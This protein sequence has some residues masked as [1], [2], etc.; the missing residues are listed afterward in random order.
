MEDTSLLVGQIPAPLSMKA[1]VF[2]LRYAWDGKQTQVRAVAVRWCFVISCLNSPIDLVKCRGDKSWNR[3]P[4]D[5]C[6]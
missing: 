4:K 3:Q 1:S 2:L 6:L 5:L